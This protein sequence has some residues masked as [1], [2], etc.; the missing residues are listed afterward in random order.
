MSIESRAKLLIDELRVS[1]KELEKLSG[2]S[3]QVWSKAFNGRQRLNSTHIE[4]LCSEYSDY[5]LW[6]TT[7]NTDLGLSP[8]GAQILEHFNEV[9]DLY[10]TVR[11]EIDYVLMIKD[12]LEDTSSVLDEYGMAGSSPI[13]SSRAKLKEK[14]YHL[15]LKEDLKDFSSRINKVS[16]SE[17]R[18]EVGEFFRKKAENE[19]IKISDT[20]GADERLT[21]MIGRLY[22]DLLLPG[23]TSNILYDN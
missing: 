3:Q 8:K 10:A 11:A 21:I 7:G 1:Q 14:Y 6:L 19:F 4:F 23:S 20:Y 2:V 9:A 18:L 5:A 15:C 16:E 17:V 12:Y 22:L 13:P